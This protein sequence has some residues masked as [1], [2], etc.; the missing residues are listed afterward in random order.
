MWMNND[1][2]RP[3]PSGGR[4]PRTTT[5]PAR[6]RT[7]VTKAPSC[8]YVCI[9]SYASCFRQSRAWWLRLGSGPPR[10]TGFNLTPRHP[11]GATMADRSRPHTCVQFLAAQSPVCI[12]SYVTASVRRIYTYQNTHACTYY[13]LQWLRALTIF[14][15]PTRPH[16][17]T[18]LKILFLV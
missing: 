18:F 1:D 6:A 13:S 15:L 10:L 11:S 14:Y 3:R 9:G 8:G 17:P 7:L 12:Y 4:D 16:L 2:A 5:A